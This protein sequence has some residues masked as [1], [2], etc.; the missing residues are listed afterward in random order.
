MWLCHK[1]DVNYMIMQRNMT[2]MERV[3]IKRNG[4]KLHGNISRNGYGDAIIGRYGGYFE[5]GYVVGLWY[6]R[7]LCC[8]REASNGG[9][10][11]VRI[12]H[13]DSTLDIKNSHTYC[14]NLLVIKTKYY[15]HAPRGI[16]W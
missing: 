3:I 1:Y 4:E 2:M 16:D 5:E 7:K 6:Q 13:M 14:K 8:T 12:I 9:K 10:V 15:A 11:R